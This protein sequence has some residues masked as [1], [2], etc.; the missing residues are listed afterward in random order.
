MQHR[1]R[2]PGPGHR[3][4]DARLG[5]GWTR[6]SDNSAGFIDLHHVLCGEAP[7]IHAASRDGQS[8]GITSDHRAEVAARPQYPATGVTLASDL[9]ERI[10][11]GG[12]GHAQGYPGSKAKTRRWRAH[13]AFHRLGTVRLPALLVL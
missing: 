6:A 13:R 10:G 1:T 7:L 4:M 8:Q 11:H 12:E 2:S 9:G 5:G 3:E